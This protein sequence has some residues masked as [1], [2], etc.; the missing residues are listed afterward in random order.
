[1]MQHGDIKL[2]TREETNSTLTHN[3]GASRLFGV[4]EL[5]PPK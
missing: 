1:M 4:V 3:S 2:N 5:L